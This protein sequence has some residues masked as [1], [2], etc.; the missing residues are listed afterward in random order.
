MP[1]SRDLSRASSSNMEEYVDDVVIA[2]R[3]TDAAGESKET[4]WINEKWKEY[5]GIYKEIPEVKIA[6]D[7]RALWTVGKGWTTDDPK[8]EIILENIKGCGIDTFHT[9][10]RNLIVTMRIAGDAYAEII[11]DE[12][13]H[14]YPI[15][16]K[17]LDP[18]SIQIVAN[19]Q[20]RIIRY[21]QVTKSRGKTSTHKFKTRDI[22]H[23]CNK[24]VADEIHGVS[25]LESLSEIIKAN[26][27]SFQINKEII[28]HFS[29][30]KMTVEID[31]DDQTKI[32]DF[33]IKFDE[34]TNK[35]E[36]L[37][38]PKGTVKPDVLAVPPN[39]TLNILPWRQHLKDYFYQVV[40]IPQIILGSSGEFTE[41]TAKIAYLA[42]QQSVEDDQLYIEDQLWSQ[43]YLKVELSFP[44]TMQNELISDESKDSA[45]G[46]EAQPQD[47]AVTQGGVI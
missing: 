36:N 27:E 39:A 11:W 23:I 24:R 35:G 14:D 4:R 33:I 5:F 25:D 17:P 31:T 9:I 20:G 8:T 40:G 43:L 1:I 42:F 6:I 44:A 22:F 37:F 10:L 13:K 19:K 2:D 16:L 3:D 21:E 47:Q 15:N 32:N 28:K 30:P 26:N 18:G 45:Q 7:S 34:A 12:Q 46:I 41:S 29:K 38:Y